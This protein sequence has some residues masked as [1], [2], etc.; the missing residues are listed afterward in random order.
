M[1]IAVVSYL[2]VVVVVV[3]KKKAGWRRME[4]LRS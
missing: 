2:F 1:M 4:Y 3:V